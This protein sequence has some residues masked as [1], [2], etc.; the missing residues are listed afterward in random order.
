MVSKRREQEREGIMKAEQEGNKKKLTGD[1]LPVP[2][3][4]PRTLAAVSSNTRSRRAHPLA[5]SR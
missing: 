5:P 2:Q 1:S 4:V 3:Q